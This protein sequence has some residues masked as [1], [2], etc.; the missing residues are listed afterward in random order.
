[1]SQQK[2]NAAYVVWGLVLLLIILHQDLWFW[3]SKTLVFGI[4]PIGLFF[5]ALI[6]LAAGSTWFLAT[7]IAWPFDESD[8]GDQASKGGAA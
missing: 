7:K 3:N 4:M 2:S 8:T 5:H 6:S 1:M